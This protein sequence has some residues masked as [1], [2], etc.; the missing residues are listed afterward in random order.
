MPFKFSLKADGIENGVQDKSAWL[1]A[2]VVIALFFLAVL[3]MVFD[4]FT[5]IKLVGAVVTAV[6]LLMLSGLAN[7]VVTSLKMKDW[8]VGDDIGTAKSVFIA[9]A[10]TLIGVCIVFF[11]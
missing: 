6:G 5:G 4:N 11:S 7:V 3:Y 2:R 8:F 1:L 9:L 10:V